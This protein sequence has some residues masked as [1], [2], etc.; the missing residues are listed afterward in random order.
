MC[1]RSAGPVCVWHRFVL[2]VPPC[3]RTNPFTALAIPHGLILCRLVGRGPPLTWY[4]VGKGACW[5]APCARIASMTIAE[6]VRAL[7]STFGGRRL[8][9]RRMPFGLRGE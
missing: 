2:V 6:G 9:T 3:C 5:L 4:V 8:L 7:V 1:A